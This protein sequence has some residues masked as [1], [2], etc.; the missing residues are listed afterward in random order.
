MRASPPRWHCSQTL[1]RAR[2][3]SRPGCTMLVRDGRARLP[4]TETIAGSTA[5]MAG[6]FRALVREGGL[7]L[8]TAVALTSAT[9]AA[10]L[11]LTDVGLLAAGRWADL[12]VLD[13]GLEVAGVLRRGRW[14]RPV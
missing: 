7:A 9:P 14:E 6:M 11:G 2:C 13:A 12:V 4:G 10:A 3:G 1:S 5:T 8:P